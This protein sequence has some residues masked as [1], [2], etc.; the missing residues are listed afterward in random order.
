MPSF[1]AVCD[2]GGSFVYCDVAGNGVQASAPD[3]VLVLIEL[4]IRKIES[5][6]NDHLSKVLFL[7]F[8]NHCLSHLAIQL[9]FVGIER[10]SKVRRVTGRLS[11]WRRLW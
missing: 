3:W 2:G 7:S 8:L 6:L 1:V 4:E 10:R 9:C 11:G 5:L